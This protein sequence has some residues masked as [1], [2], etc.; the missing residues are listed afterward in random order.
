MACGRKQWRG[1]VKIVSSAPQEAEHHL[2]CSRCGMLFP[3]SERLD[4]HERQCHLA[5]SVCGVLFTGILRLREI[6]EHG[7]LTY[8]CDYCTKRF[9]H[10]VHRDLRVKARHTVEKTCHCD[11]CGKGYSCV[12]VL[13]THRM[14]HFD[15]TFI[16][17]VCGKGFYHACHLTRHKLVHLDKR[18]HQ[19]ATCGRG[20]TQTSNLRSHQ[21]S[22]SGEWQLCSVCGKSY[23]CLR[24][25][26]K[27]ISK[28]SHELPTH[29]LP[30]SNSIAACQVCDRK[31]PNMS[32][33]RVHQLQKV[34]PREGA[35]ARP[36]LH[37]QQREALPYFNMA[38]S[39]LRHHSVHSGETPHSCCD[40]GKQFCLVAFLKAHLQTRAHLQ[41]RAAAT[42]L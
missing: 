23:R 35:A 31:F 25:H 10:T 28:H 30:A 33:L 42:H 22:H 16:C 18:P 6:K 39:F 27:Q 24:K 19:C 41:R 12:S 9:N 17:N 21:A 1:H 5:C 37:P 40:C 38:A 8:A 11:I 36:P 26:G 29:E 14:T 20:F 2:L 32:Q 7:L 4:D 15:K 34:L 3:N 13:K